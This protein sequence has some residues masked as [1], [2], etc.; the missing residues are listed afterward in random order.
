MWINFTEMPA[1]LAA[2]APF[3]WAPMAAAMVGSGSI[4]PMWTGQDWRP[5]LGTSVD[6]RIRPPFL[7]TKEGL[8]L[9]SRW[10][11][12][13]DELNIRHAVNSWLSPAKVN[14]ALGPDCD[15]SPHPLQA[16]P[17]D[18]G[19]IPCNEWRPRSL[20]RWWGAR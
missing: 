7:S 14:V 20:S 5:I 15:T 6:T 12:D 13:R 8:L 18:L 3:G 16:L 1:S 11:R 19:A 2:L 9:L 10:I 4:P 17:A